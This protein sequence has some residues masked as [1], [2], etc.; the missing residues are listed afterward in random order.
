MDK[1]AFIGIAQIKMDDLDPQMRP[2]N[3]W[4]KL[5]HNTSLAGTAPVRKDSETSLN[6]IK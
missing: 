3:A 4:Y 6:E 5:F 2:I 1:K